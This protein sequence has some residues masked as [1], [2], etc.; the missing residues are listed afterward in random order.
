MRKALII[1]GA[2]VLGLIAGIFIFNDAK[3]VINGADFVGTLWLNALRMTIIPLVVSLL[4]VGVVQTAVM[5]R[6]GRMT[7]RGIATMIFILWC[8]APMRM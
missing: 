1:I 8:S 7:F 4:I 3:Y 6:A 5:A 2:L